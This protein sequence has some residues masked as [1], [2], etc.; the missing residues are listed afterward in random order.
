MNSDNTRFLTTLISFLILG[1]AAVHGQ[2]SNQDFLDAHN[3]ARRNVG[4]GPMTWDVNVAN[5]ARNYVNS[6]LGDCNM[7]HSP[8]RPGYGENLAKGSG[9]FTGRAAVNLWVSEKQYYNYGSNSCAPGRVCGHYTQVVWRNSN[10]LGCA[11]AR[12]A[13]GWWFVSCNYAPAG[14]WAGQRPY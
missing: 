3:A 13:N 6:R 14:N 12:C 1:G 10:R 7:V 8:N 2:N 11:R 5:F 4:V 9:A